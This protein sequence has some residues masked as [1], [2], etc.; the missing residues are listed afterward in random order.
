MRQ[1]NAIINAAAAN[2]AEAAQGRK[3]GY[4]NQKAPPKMLENLS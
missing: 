4:L 2:E 1:I 3:Y